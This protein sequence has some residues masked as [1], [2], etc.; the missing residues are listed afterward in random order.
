MNLFRGIPAALSLYTRIPVKMKNWKDG[1]MRRAFAFFPL[2]GC[3]IGV[4]SVLAWLL[5][6][7]YELPVFFQTGILYL[8][9]LAVTGGLH[10][11]GFM[12]VEDAAGSWGDREKKL[13]I[14]K[15]PHIGAFAV[16]GMIRHTVFCLAMI[17]LWAEK[18]AIREM[19]FYGFLFVLSRSVCGISSVVLKKARQDGMLYEE[20]KG[21]SKG[22]LTAFLIWTAAAAAGMGA[23]SPRKAAAAAGIFVLL[24]LYYRRFAYRH[25]GGV[26][27]DTAGYFVIISEGISLVSVFF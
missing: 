8:I 26:T 12:D 7:R 27:G 25:F 4:L 1:D 24:F 15:D 21:K 3:L 23:V 18:A 10:A 6:R 22:L 14:L 13:A 2:A 17:S 20:T 9:P 19:V 5:C 11:D 16:L